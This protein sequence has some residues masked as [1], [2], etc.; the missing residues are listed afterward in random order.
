MLSLP[1]CLVDARH[2]SPANLLGFGVDLENL[3]D[4]VVG[5]HVRQP[6]GAEQHPVAA[7]Q[8]NFVNLDFHVERICP[9]GIGDNVAQAMVSGLLGRQYAV[10]DQLFHDGVVAG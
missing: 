7:F 8:V 1:L 4:L 5:D 2:K 10:A 3:V 9:D 6:I